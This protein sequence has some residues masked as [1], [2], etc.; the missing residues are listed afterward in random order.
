MKTLKNTIILFLLSLILINCSS[1]PTD[2]TDPCTN[3][4]IVGFSLSDYPTTNTIRQADLTFG[5]FNGNG[6]INTVPPTQSVT[7]GRMSPNDANAFNPNTNIYSFLMTSS[8]KIT[9][10]DKSNNTISEVDLPVG[11]DG[12]K[13]LTY[14]QITDKYYTVQTTSNATTLYEFSIP[15]LTSPIVFS[16]S[17]TLYTGTEA[18]DAV[19]YQS[20]F[21]LTTNNAGNLYILTNKDIIV[22]DLTNFTT[23]TPIFKTFSNPFSSPDKFSGIEYD[24]VNNRLLYLSSS[25]NNNFLEL[26]ETSLPI[27]TAYGN[28]VVNLNAYASDFNYEFH[29]TVLACDGSYIISNHI[30][31]QPQIETRFIKVDANNTV[32]M[33]TI[34]NHI[35]GFQKIN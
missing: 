5:E 25:P 1:N 8:H 3:K 9:N 22:V 23:T 17:I 29:S 13:G 26:R 6:F 10:F 19:L 32:N 15:N 34:P 7:I 2:P 21:G 14:S 31:N 30:D 11:F 28:S 27:G 35:F 18:S 4:K 16:N 12:C 33:V 24:D 20:Y